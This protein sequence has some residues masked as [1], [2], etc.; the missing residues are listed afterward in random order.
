MEKQSASE[1]GEIV[2]ILAQRQGKTAPL[3][4]AFA[5]FVVVALV[6]AVALFGDRDGDLGD[7]EV[8]WG[9][10]GHLKPC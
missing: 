2:A 1:G 7:G 6:R 5:F 9:G 8:G 3:V 4:H 10:V